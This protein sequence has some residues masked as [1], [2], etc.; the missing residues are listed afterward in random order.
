[1]IPEDG[2]RT[3]LVVDDTP[4]AIAVLEGILKKDYRVKAA[5]S[6]EF[7]L[8]VASGAPVPDL[9]LLD[10]AMPGMDGFETC[11]RLKQDGATARI[12]VIF[13]TS[14]TDFADEAAGFALGAVD[15]ITK[16]VNPHLVRARVNVQLELKEAREELERQNE[17]LRE[18]ARL[19]EQVEAINHHDLKNPL[20]VI[21]AVPSVVL[22]NPTLT[23]RE[24]KLLGMVRDAGRR[25]LEMIN[26]AVDIFKMEKGAYVLKPTAVDLLGAVEQIENSFNGPAAEK[27][28]TCRVTVRGEAPQQGDTFTVKGE[29][30]LV[31]SLLA[32]LYKNAVE[33]SPP[34]GMISVSIDGGEYATIAI[35]NAGAIPRS[36]R[37]RF[38][39]KFAT[40]GKDRGTGLGAYSARLIAHTL[41]GAISF[42]STEESGTTISVRLPPA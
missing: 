7:A 10:V 40:A 35:H 31:Y 20:T 13:V 30:L 26:R 19:R 3:I 39:E 34:G 27:N 37:G 17:E 24:R 41:G 11:R 12:P 2:R 22:A 36:I 28:L 21:L 42:D 38:F 16:P 29:D 15:Y 32:N 1:M 6:G 5:T 33:A 18:T 4:D 8:E 14:K 25:M 9:I 23:E